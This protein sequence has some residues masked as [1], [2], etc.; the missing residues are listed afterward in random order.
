MFNINIKLHK[1]NSF[2]FTV[3]WMLLDVVSFSSKVT[4]KCSSVKKRQ[5][6]SIQNKVRVKKIILYHLILKSYQ[7]DV[8]FCLIMS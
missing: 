7:Y 4:W 3:F 8:L 2:I 1:I 6:N 5:L